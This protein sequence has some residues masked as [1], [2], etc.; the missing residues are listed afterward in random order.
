[1]GRTPVSS[2][3]GA[4]TTDGGRAARRR[5]D[6]EHRQL[7]ALLADLAGSTDLARI[8]RRLDDLRALLVTH[9]E[10][11]EGPDGMHEIVR[12]GAA[13][14]LPNVQRLFE[15][16]REMLAQLDRLRS[17]VASCLAGPVAVVL[18]GVSALAESLARHEADEEQLFAEAFYS[19]I[20]GR[21]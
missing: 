6:Q 1:M 15:E 8:G 11:E 4:D 13:H 14:R 3:S 10:T 5:I 18:G 19:D 17:E 20:G 2:A 16:H 12:E 7:D 9:F 21:S